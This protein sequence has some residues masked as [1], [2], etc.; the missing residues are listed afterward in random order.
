MHYATP[1]EH[2]KIYGNEFVRDL[3]YK[4]TADVFPTIIY[5]RDYNNEPVIRFAPSQ[6]DFMTSYHQNRL[7]AEWVDY[8]NSNKL[9][10]KEVHA[11]TSL[12]QMVFNALCKQS[13]IESLRIKWLNCKDISQVVELNHLKKLFIELG[14]KIE[15]ITPIAKLHDM[16]VLILGE[17]VKVVDYSP[18]KELK[19]LKVFSISRYQTS[20]KER[21]KIKS[22]DFLNEMKSLEYVDLVDVKCDTR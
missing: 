2:Y 15:D 11:V 14:T 16:E 5:P 12:T 6:H 13:S 4:D 21:I 20:T 3:R 1:E 22:L 9:P 8:L 19:K 7:T 18:L 17:T 10:L